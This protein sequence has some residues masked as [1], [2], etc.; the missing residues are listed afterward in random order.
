MSKKFPILKTGPKPERVKID[1]DWKD[2][3]GDA[4]KK[5][6]PADG[7]PNSDKKKS[8]NKE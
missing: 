4:L 6:R 2:A 7:W 1:G 5:P 3:V 8:G